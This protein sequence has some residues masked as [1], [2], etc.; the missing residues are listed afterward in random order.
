MLKRPKKSLIVHTV[1]IF[2]EGYGTWLL[3]L[4]KEQNRE[5]SN[6]NPILNLENNTQSAPKFAV[7]FD[8][9]SARARQTSK[10]TTSLGPDSVHSVTF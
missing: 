3:H 10:A 9:S 6:I 8:I 4:Y 7:T 2:L 1:N 5:Y